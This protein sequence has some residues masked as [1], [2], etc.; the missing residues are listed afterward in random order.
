MN[1]VSLTVSSVATLV[2]FNLVLLGLL[3]ELQLKAS[4]VFRHR[5]MVMVKEAVR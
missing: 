5:T 1:L 3:A 4:R 2:G